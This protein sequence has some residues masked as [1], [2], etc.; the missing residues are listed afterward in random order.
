VGALACANKIRRRSVTNNLAE[1]SHVVEP[2]L[3][4]RVLVELTTLGLRDV[5]SV[6]AVPEC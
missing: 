6:H 5:P 2:H 3:S 4:H 1:A